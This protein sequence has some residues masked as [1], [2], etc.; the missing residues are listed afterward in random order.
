MIQKVGLSR[1]TLVGDLTIRSSDEFDVVVVESF[2]VLLIQRLPIERF[3][4]VDQLTD[5]FPSVV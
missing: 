4:F 5:E 2:R 1:Y 3:V